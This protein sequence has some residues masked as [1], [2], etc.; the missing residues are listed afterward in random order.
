MNDYLPIWLAIGRQNR[1]VR[2]ACDPVFDET[3]FYACSNVAE[4]MEKL[5]QGN[6]SLGTAFTLGTLCFI[7]QDNGGDEWLTIKED[8]PFESMSCGWMIKKR[9]EAYF[10]AIIEAIQ[11]ASKDNCR[12]LRYMPEESNNPASSNTA[13]MEGL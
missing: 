10:A 7:Q 2:M 4:L 6:W 8:V 9:G 13:S 5:K 3:S 12:M 1:W 11:R